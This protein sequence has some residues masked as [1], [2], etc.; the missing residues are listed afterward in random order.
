MML[1]RSLVLGL[2]GALLMLQV[3]Q[4]GA[5]PLEGE[6]RAAPPPV[7]LPT[8]V[9]VSR[10]ALAAGGDVAPALGLRPGER[11]AAIDDA[12]VTDTLAAVAAIRGARAGQYL[13]LDVM[14]A[15]R[16]RRVLVLVH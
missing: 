16:A 13:D 1:Y 15:G 6:A 12:P 11:I 10:P 4:N 7:D 5:P 9:D 3:A 2:V 8:I 14:R